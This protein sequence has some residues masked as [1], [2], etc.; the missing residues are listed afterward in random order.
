MKMWRNYAK[1]RFVVDSNSVFIWYIECSYVDVEKH[2][3]VFLVFSSII[4]DM[5]AWQERRLFWKHL[6]V[7]VN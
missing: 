6:Y 5:L 7:I 1:V 2:D 3:M 4:R